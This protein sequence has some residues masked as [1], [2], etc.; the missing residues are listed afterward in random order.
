MICRKSKIRDLHVGLEHGPGPLDRPLFLVILRC[1]P[2]LFQNRY[3]CDTD[4]CN[5]HQ[6][7]GQRII[8]DAS[9]L[10]SNSTG[11][12]YFGP[13]ISDLIIRVHPRIHE[14]PGPGTDWSESVRDFQNSS[15]PVWDLE[16]FLSCGPIPGFEIFLRSGSKFQIFDG[17]GLVRVRFSDRFLDR[18]WNRF[19][20][21]DPWASNNFMIIPEKE[22]K[23]HQLQMV[24]VKQSFSQSCYLY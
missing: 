13:S 23:T 19:G 3:D 5:T 20:S 6:L 22:C 21:A 8:T 16:F 4:G 1:W 9:G 10:N 17:P 18:F 14:S 24:S 11:K 2:I 7:D 15:G 12:D